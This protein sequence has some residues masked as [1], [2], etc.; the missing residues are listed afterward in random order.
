MRVLL[1]AFLS[2]ALL[3]TPVHAETEIGASGMCFDE[4][5]AGGG[6]HVAVNDQDGLVT[7]GADPTQ[8]GGIVDALLA[9]RNNEN[10]GGVDNCN[11]EHAGPEDWLEVHVT[12]DVASVQVCYSYGVHLDGSCPT[13]YPA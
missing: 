8:P 5:G 12:T 11:Q 3:S 2:L 6:G 13:R 1:A 10:D 7:Q 4:S 9:Y